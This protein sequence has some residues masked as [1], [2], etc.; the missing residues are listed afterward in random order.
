MKN[1]RSAFAFIVDTRNRGTFDSEGPVFG[2]RHD[3]FVGKI[4]TEVVHRKNKAMYGTADGSS[5]G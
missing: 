2:I 1:Y 5:Y 3:I 4:F